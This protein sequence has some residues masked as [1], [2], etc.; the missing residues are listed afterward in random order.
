MNIDKELLKENILENIQLPDNLE[1]L[2]RDSVEEG[3]E[4]M[5]KRKSRRMLMVRRAAATIGIVAGGLAAAVPVKAFIGSLVTERMEQVPGEEIDDI[6]Q[7]LQEQTVDAD[8]FSREYTQEER[9]RLGELQSAYGQGT[10]PQKELRQEETDDASIVDELYFTK[11]TSTFYLPGRGLTDEELLEII[12]FNAKRD[13]ALASENEAAKEEEQEKILAAGKEMEAAGGISADRALALGKE[14]LYNLHGLTEE[15]MEKNC[16][17]E[18]MAAEAFGGPVY[19]VS[20]V[21]KGKAAYNFML[22][23]KDGVL[24]SATQS[25][26]ARY[27]EAPVSVQVL[28]EK[29]A[30]LTKKAKDIFTVQLGK[31]EDYSSIICSWYDAD[32]KLGDYNG[33][34]WFFINKDG[35]AYQ[36]E[37][38][39]PSEKMTYF[40]YLE[41]FEE[42]RKIKAEGE[43]LLSGEQSVLK[44][45]EGLT[46]YKEI[47]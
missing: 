10:F 9:E 42:Y 21:M 32:G 31:S 11:D 20:Y 25:I 41:N 45:V 23:A 7:V 46:V 17:L 47:E 26:N 2:V 34:S 8:S 30:F 1:Q 37:M 40:A 3:Y 35:S 39:V 13:Y 6:A 22:S 19:F 15:G 38:D 28:E 14:W 18:T 29:S 12:D 16:F 43:E 36:I 33:A 44:P 27:E 24:L 5:K 4:N